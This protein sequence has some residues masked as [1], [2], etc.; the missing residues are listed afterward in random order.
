MQAM[1]EYTLT[2]AASMTLQQLT[3][4]PTLLSELQPVTVKNTL[5]CWSEL[6]N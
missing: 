1:R 3:V 5:I 6:P 2:S 4:M